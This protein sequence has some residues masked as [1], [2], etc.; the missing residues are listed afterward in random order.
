M[1]RERDILRRLIKLIV[2]TQQSKS[3]IPNVDLNV[4]AT[5]CNR[6]CNYFCI[7]YTQQ[8]AQTCDRLQYENFRSNYPRTRW[9]DLLLECI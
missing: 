6:R 1:Y 8:K 4:N 2:R 5:I 3:T 7:G 9:P